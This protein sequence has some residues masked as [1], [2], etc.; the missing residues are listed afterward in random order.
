MTMSTPN[1][2]RHTLEKLLAT[3]PSRKTALIYPLLPQIELALASG[4]TCK[5]LWE[6]LVGDG[7][8]VGYK[9]FY[10]IIHRAQKK[11][12]TSATPS[13]KSAEL[14]RPFAQDGASAVEH[15]PLVNLRKVQASRPG[16]HFRATKSLD[17][18]VHG[19]RD[20]SEQ[21]KR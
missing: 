6:S 13:G 21:S 7:L 19:R 11:H 4:W 16:F 20:S 1:R 5:E 2:Y 12:R 3:Q 15:D 9:T 18:L 10:T 8:D 17:E 14:P